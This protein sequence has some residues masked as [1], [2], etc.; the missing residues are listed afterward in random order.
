L[1]TKT[2]QLQNINSIKI[3]IKKYKIIKCDNHTKLLYQLM[4]SVMS[5]FVI[6]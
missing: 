4:S 6:K 2:T 3:T 1:A 5:L